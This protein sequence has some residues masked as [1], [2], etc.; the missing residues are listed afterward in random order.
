LA[1]AASAVSSRTAIN[2][3]LAPSASARIQTHGCLRPN[4]YPVWSQ[5]SIGRCCR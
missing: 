1:G 4:R 2:R 5:Q 3:R